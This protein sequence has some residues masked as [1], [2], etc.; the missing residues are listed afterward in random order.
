MAD[1]KALE[2][3]QDEN[4]L[5]YNAYAESVE[6]PIDL[7]NSHFR[8]YDLRKCNLKN[9]DLTNAYLRASDLRGVDLSNAKLD[10]ASLRDAKVS[11][12][13]FTRDLSSEEIT[14]SLVHGTRIRQGL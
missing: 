7:T 3:I 8:G 14:M 9:A 1:A 5:E 13:L 11:G 2:L 12:A 6:G 10:G 4:I